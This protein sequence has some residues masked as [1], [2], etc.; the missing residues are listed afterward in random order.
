MKTN[1]GITLIALT[2]TIIVLIILAS[3]TTYSGISTVK[4][5]KLNKFKQELEIMQAE[6][7]VLYEKYKDNLDT[8]DIGKDIS[9]EIDSTKKAQANDAFT[10]CGDVS[11]EDKTGYRLFDNETIKELDIEGID[12][13]Y[14]V[15]VAKRD[16]ICL[17]G[18]K[19]DG[20]IYYRLKDL[21]EKNNVDH[22]VEDEGEVTFD[23]NTT[24]LP[25]GKCEFNIS[26]IK[27]SKYVG[28]GTIT[29]KK[30]EL[31]S[32]WSTPT[33]VEKEAKE[34]ANY[35]FTVNKPGRY[36]IIIEDAIGKS[37]DKEITITIDSSTSIAGKKYTDEKDI[38]VNGTPI[39]VPKGVTISGIPGEYEKAENGIVIY[40][41]KD[42]DGDGTIDSPDWNDPE[43][44]KT[45]YDQFVWVP[46]KNAIAKDKNNDGKVDTTDIDLMIASEEYPMA[47]A[48]DSINYRGILYNF[49]LTDGNVV[50]SD[51]TWSEDSTSNREP[52]YLED[53]DPF[54]IEMTE[55]SLQE[56]FNTMVNRVSSQKGFWVGR[57]ETSNMVSD[58]T[59]DSTNKITII[60]G[61]TTGINN[62]YWYRMYTQQK[63]YS[64]LALGET[65]TATSSMIWGSQWDQIMIW[66]KN[67][68]NKNQD[69]KYIFNS[70]GMGNYGTISGVDDG[71]NSTTEPAPTGYKE[72]YKVKNIYDL[73]GNLDDWTLEGDDRYL[74]ILRGGAYNDTTSSYIGADFRGRADSSSSNSNCGSR[75][76]LY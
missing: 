19:Q 26:N 43:K 11:D 73:A 72:I 51:L 56:E 31:D 75:A 50:V 2:L 62:V 45:T 67:V 65:T 69:S 12:R 59:K 36:K 47:I 27:F 70:I 52:A 76:V 25:E 20:K 18:F 55:S 61:T 17:E 37:A 40:I 30:L 22:Y 54:D 13:E 44:M 23:L 33:T 3:V 34:N 57:Y 7:N 8:I 10:V 35:N 63:S 64:K 4:S 16:V 32:T 71:W 9:T 1:R 5:S 42:A 28:K 46:V 38:I 66:M 15:N 21:T 39:T 48:T 24:Q 14:L 49:T 74:R 41:M 60:Q 68:D 53:S 6:V 58:N 29:Y